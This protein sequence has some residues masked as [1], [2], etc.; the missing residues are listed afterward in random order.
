[1]VRRRGSEVTFESGAVG[2]GQC[3]P[4][5]TNKGEEAPRLTPVTD[6]Q[7][8]KRHILLEGKRVV[9]ETAGRE[10][11]TCVIQGLPPRGILQK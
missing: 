4:G 11:S 8:F 2:E 7:A 10:P 6:S 5:S 1:M 3:L 9:F